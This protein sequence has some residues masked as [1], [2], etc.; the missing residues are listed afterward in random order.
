MNKIKAWFVA[1][2][3]VILAAGFVISLHS[4]A[5]WSYH[6]VMQVLGWYGLLQA[7]AHIAALG[8]GAGMV[9]EHRGFPVQRG[10]PQMLLIP[11]HSGFKAGGSV[12]AFI[13]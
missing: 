13:E 6:T 1:A 4:Y 2:V 9:D 10:I 11:I 7:G 3:I 5:I 12:K 8:S